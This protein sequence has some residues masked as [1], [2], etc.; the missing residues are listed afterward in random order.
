MASSSESRLRGLLRA[1]ETIVSDLALPAVLR[2]IAEA[3]RELMGAQYA[4]LGVIAP[5]GHL[6]E[7]VHLG[8]DARTVTR[9]GR[10]PQGKGLLGT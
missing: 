5:D 8:M 7:F 10:L 2:R 4:A 1:N 9:I 3:A 6:S